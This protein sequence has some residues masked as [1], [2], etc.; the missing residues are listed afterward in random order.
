MPP[1]RR[2]RIEDP[3]TGE[4][5]AARPLPQR[6]VVRPQQAPPAPTRPAVTPPP[7]A[8]VPPRMRPDVA[9]R[10]AA[11][12]R[13]AAAAV[14]AGPSVDAGRAAAVRPGMPSVPARRS[15]ARRAAPAV[16][17][18]ARRPA[19]SAGAVRG[20][21]AAI[22]KLITLAEGMTV[23]DLADKLEVKVKDVLK[24]LMDRR[25][26]M[27]INSTLDSDTATDASR[28]TSAPKC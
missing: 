1:T 17:D 27:T 22:T 20:A 10:A 3:L 5:P 18:A 2:L 7:A 13:A 14:A 25:M 11:A 9:R 26:M 12:W 4:A 16:G 6:P 21:A 28:A 15:S 23:K 19:V 8:H 24:K